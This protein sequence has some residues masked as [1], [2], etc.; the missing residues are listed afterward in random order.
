MEEI[1]TKTVTRGFAQA[2]EI[3]L[4]T[5]S[6]TRLLFRP[7]VHDGGVRGVFI[8]QKKGRSEEWQDTQSINF[9]TL[10]SG[11]GVKLELGTQELKTLFQKL[12]ALYKISEKGVG[13]DATPP[14]FTTKDGKEWH[15]RVEST[16][17]AIIT[18]VEFHS[19]VKPDK[20]YA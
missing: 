5:T 12:E 17:G 14:M 2:D 1:K 18:G 19:Q 6:T 4:E 16:G 8:R 9:N 13:V 20:P 15:L 3:I 10:K 7:Q 11:D